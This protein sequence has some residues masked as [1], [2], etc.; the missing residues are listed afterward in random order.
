[1]IKKIYP[2]LLLIVYCLLTSLPVILPYFH[3]GYFPTHDGEWAVIRLG[4]M[5]RSLRDHQFPV[6]FS[7]NLNF[8]YGYPLFNFTYPA[9]YYIGVLFHFLKFGFVDTIKILFALSVVL[10]AIGMFLLSARLWGHKMAGFISAFL[11]VYFPYRI[12]DLYARGQLVNHFLLLSF[13]LFFFS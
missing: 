1:M 4:D 2:G 10:S 12:V 8:G 11:Y 3:P 13:R 9:P 6:R 7:G 5:F